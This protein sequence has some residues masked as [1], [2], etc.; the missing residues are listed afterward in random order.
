MKNQEGKSK[1]NV[2]FDETPK[3]RD[4][5]R[6]I[7][8]IFLHKLY[9]SQQYLRAWIDS[10]GKKSFRNLGPKLIRAVAF[11]KEGKGRKEK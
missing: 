11:P 3:I 4:H 6:E 9:L 10:Y 7:S 1:Q 5:H 8:F 2:P